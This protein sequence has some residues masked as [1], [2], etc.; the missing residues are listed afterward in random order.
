MKAYIALHQSNP[1]PS[2]WIQFICGPALSHGQNPFVSKKIYTSNMSSRHYQ[3]RLSQLIESLK[4]YK[5]PAFCQCTILRMAGSLREVITSTLP[6]LWRFM[7]VL[8]VM[9]IS[10][11]S[12][13]QLAILRTLTSNQGNPQTRKTLES[14][15]SGRFL[16]S[17]AV[18]RLFSRNHR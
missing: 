5:L 12:G 15:P 6:P 2:W 17:I 18:G 11:T 4:S 3:K 7:L 9:F 14:W 10:V 13:L 16:F 8:V 1:I